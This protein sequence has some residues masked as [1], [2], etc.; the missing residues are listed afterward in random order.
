MKILFAAPDRDLLE[1]YKKLLVDDFGETVT[2]FDGTQVMSLLSAERFDAAVIDASLPRIECEKLIKSARDRNVPVIILSENVIS[3]ERLCSGSVASSGLAYPFT[4]HE[5]KD[6]LID[7]LEKSES[8]E[9]IRI[10]G[11]EIKVRDFRIT[12]GPYVTAGE[13]NTLKEILDGRDIRHGDEIYMDSLNTKLARC[14]TGARIRYVPK[15]G[16]RLV[17]ENG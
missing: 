9:I 5:L 16:Y 13:I 1:C 17:T 2:A 14:G 15:K 11:L 7:V 4:P 10:Q 8:E 3:S 12:G 6:A